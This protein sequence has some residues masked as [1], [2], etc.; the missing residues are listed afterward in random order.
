MKGKIVKILK[1]PKTYCSLVFI[2]LVI[3]PIVDLDYLLNDFLK[4]YHL[5]V[6]STVNS[7][8]RTSSTCNHR[9]FIY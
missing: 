3:Q 5:I 6:P 8:S 4:Q 2:F 7:F 1:S 9:L